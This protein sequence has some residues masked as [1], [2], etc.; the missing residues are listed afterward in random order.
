MHQHR[1]FQKCLEVAGLGTHRHILSGPFVH[2]PAH[3]GRLQ[4]FWSL[5]KPSCLSSNVLEPSGPFSTL[6]TMGMRT[7]CHVHPSCAPATHTTPHA[8]CRPLYRQVPRA[9]CCICVRWAYCLPCTTCMGVACIGHSCLAWASLS[10]CL[11]GVRAY[12]R[13]WWVGHRA[14]HHCWCT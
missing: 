13:A 3:F 6:L 12:V 2:I 14:M 9:S 4:A 5:S 8:A 1:S 10:G 7:G 11:V